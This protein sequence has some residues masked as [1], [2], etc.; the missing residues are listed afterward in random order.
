MPGTLTDNTICNSQLVSVPY[1]TVQ[2]AIELTDSDPF[3]MTIR[4]PIEWAAIAQAVNQGIDAHLEACNLQGI[5]RYDNGICSVSPQSL[6]VLLRRF[7]D[8]EFVGTDK[9]GAGDIWDAGMSLQSS[10][11]TVLG[12][13][14]Y[15]HYVGREAL[16]ME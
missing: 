16:G 1:S 11:F 14:E 7:G 13:D 15:G 12:I 10:I 5:D 2:R 6:C 8:T 9:H 4:C 3:N